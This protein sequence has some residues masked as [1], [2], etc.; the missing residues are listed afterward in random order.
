MENINIFIGPLL[1]ALVGFVISHFLTMKR[2]SRLKQIEL[3]QA[4]ILKWHAEKIIFY[5][6]LYWMATRVQLRDSWAEAIRMFEEMRDEVVRRGI[7]CDDNLILEIDHL[8]EGLESK[9][10]NEVTIALNRVK[11]RIADYR[12]AYH[13]VKLSAGWK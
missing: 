9:N 5:E 2:D 7:Y 10:E 12:D 6:R 3:N 13:E 11:K 1:G 8:K 4:V